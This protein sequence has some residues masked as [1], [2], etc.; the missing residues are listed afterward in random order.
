M[1][2]S[3]IGVT[4]FKKSIGVKRNYFNV[5]FAVIKTTQY[6]SFKNTCRGLCF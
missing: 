1:F 6:V 3:I 4:D 5:D 2:R